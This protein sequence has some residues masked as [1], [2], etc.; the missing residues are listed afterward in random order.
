MDVEIQA[1]GLTFITGAGFVPGVP[2]LMERYLAGYFDTVDT[3]KMGGLLKEKRTSYGSCADLIPTLVDSPMVFS[4]GSDAKSPFDRIRRTLGTCWIGRLL[5]GSD[6]VPEHG[7]VRTV[8]VTATG[9]MNGSKEQLRLT[10]EHRD[11]YR[12]TAI[13]TVP[14]VL[15]LLDG[16][17][18]QPGVHMMGHVLDPEQYMDDLWRMGMT[19]SLQGLPETWDEKSRLDEAQPDETRPDKTRADITRLI[20]Q[21]A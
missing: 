10:L 15:G 6:C 9:T 16:P 7:Q 1:E 3:V 17:I 4:D 2:A 18:K 20:E 19:V 13:F 11:S 14:C 12:A 8:R 5:R 21:V